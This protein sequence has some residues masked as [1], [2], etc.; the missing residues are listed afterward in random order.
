MGP[1]MPSTPARSPHP[2]PEPSSLASS[3]W[4]A[5]P[6][7]GSQL[8]PE[9]PSLP[10]PEGPVGLAPRLMDL[11]RRVEA[12]GGGLRH[13]REPGLSQ[14][15]PA[16]AR[17]PYPLTRASRCVSQDSRA[18]GTSGSRRSEG[19]STLLPLPSPPIS[20]PPFPPRAPDPELC[21]FTL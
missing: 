18:L 10:A 6:S 21:S 17:S 2:E 15:T 13:K 7:I 5:G 9:C 1:A 11:C 8:C 14:H 12:H 20:H 19:N 4:V 16:P 3:A